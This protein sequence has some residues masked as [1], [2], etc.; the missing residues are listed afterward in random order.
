MTK[1]SGRCTKKMAKAVHNAWRKTID[2]WEHGAYA[3]D[4]AVAA[5]THNY[6]E[7]CGLCA[8]PPVVGRNAFNDEN[9]CC[10]SAESH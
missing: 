3:V 10:V 6:V 9:H 1:Q 4:C 8:L 7:T 2:S 5:K